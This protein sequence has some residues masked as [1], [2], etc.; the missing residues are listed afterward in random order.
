[1]PSTRISVMHVE[2]CCPR[3][4]CFI[5]SGELGRRFRGKFTGRFSF[6]LLRAGDRVPKEQLEYP[7]FQLGGER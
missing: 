1:M 2:R 5:G 3:F 4:E 6:L 7:A